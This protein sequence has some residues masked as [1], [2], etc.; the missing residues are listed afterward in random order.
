MQRVPFNWCVIEVHEFY[1]PTPQQG[2]SGI[3]DQDWVEDIRTL[4]SGSNEEVAQKL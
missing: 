2:G 1:L 3:E 4:P